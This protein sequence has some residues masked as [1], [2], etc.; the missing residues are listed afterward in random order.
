MADRRDINVDVVE[1]KEAMWSEF[2]ELDL[3]ALTPIA[4]LEQL[5]RMQTTVNALNER[6][7]SAKRA[8]G[9]ARPSKAKG[10]QPVKAK[11]KAKSKAKSNAKAKAKATPK[12]KSTPKLRATAAAKAK[13]KAKPRAA[14]TAVAHQGVK[15][16]TRSSLARLRATGTVEGTATVRSKRRRARPG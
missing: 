11:A 12:A 9:G 4:A 3:D 16:K 2:G 14:A 1:A 5:L 13:A 8:V 15:R 10:K 7:A 6:E